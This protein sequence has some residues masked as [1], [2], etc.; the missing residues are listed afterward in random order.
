VLARLETDGDPARFFLATCLLTPV[1]HTAGST[2]PSNRGGSLPTIPDSGAAGAPCDAFHRG[3]D[4]N[5]WIQSQ[6]G[7]NAMETVDR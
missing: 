2:C 1:N 7:R 4:R 6:F 5:R 3:S